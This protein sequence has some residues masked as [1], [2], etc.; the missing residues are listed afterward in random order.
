MSITNR[1]G[2]RNSYKQRVYAI[3]GFSFELNFMFQN[4]VR[5]R[6]T[7]YSMS[8]LTFRCAAFLNPPLPHCI[9]INVGGKPFGI[10]G[11]K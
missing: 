9:N 6:G 8:G 1:L 2:G 11:I 5:S 10:T 7:I 3:A 4:V